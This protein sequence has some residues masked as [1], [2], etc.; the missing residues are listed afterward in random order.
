MFGFVVN[1]V[2]SRTLWFSKNYI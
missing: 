1:L 2:E